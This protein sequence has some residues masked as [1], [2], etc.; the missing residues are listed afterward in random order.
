MMLYRIK[1][2]F[3]GLTYK[4][5]PEDKCF[6]QRYLNKEELK[7]FYKLSK[8]EQGHCIRTAYDIKKIL[9]K[10]KICNDEL[11]KIGLLH[12]IGKIHCKLNLIEKS[13]LVLLDK[14]TKSKLRKF[15]NLKK[16]NIYYN[17]GEIGCNLLKNY[18]YSERFLYLVK[19]HHDNDI[20][21]DIELDILK[22][23]DNRN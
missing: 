23:C 4:I 10:N 1:Q 5:T 20:I 16:I 11:I 6:L 22:K 7:L 2:F 15:I 3:L 12:D 17:H 9:M 14:L 19:K 13:I 21:G 18:K 8:D